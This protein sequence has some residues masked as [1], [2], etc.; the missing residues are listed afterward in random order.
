MECIGRRTNDVLDFIISICEEYI[1][2]YLIS[3]KHHKIVYILYGDDDSSVHMFVTNLSS[4][5]RRF[6]YNKQGGLLNS[7]CV[8][9]FLYKSHYEHF[10][11]KIGMI[12]SW[13]IS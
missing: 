3:I 11:H 4:L 2:Q 10:I 9:S 1:S 13:R 8:Y 7:K 6:V 5:R 12:Q